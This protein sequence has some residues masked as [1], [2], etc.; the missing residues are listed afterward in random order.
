MP[1]NFLKPSK[2]PVVGSLVHLHRWTRCPEAYGVLIEVSDIDASAKVF[3]S[4]SV[5]GLATFDFKV[6]V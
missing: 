3:V 1:P 2:P 5:M 4:G 6:I